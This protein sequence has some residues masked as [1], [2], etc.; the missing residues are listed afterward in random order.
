M[1]RHVRGD[2]DYPARDSFV[3]GSEV[4]VVCV[5]D[6]GSGHSH[7][8]G[9]GSVGRLCL[10]QRFRIFF[11]LGVGGVERVRLTEQ[12][13]HIVPKDVL[14]FDVG[15]L[16]TPTNNVGASSP[17]G[18]VEPD[19]VGNVQEPMR[20][21]RQRG[22]ATGKGQSHHQRRI[23]DQVSHSLEYVL[24]EDLR[25][26]WRKTLHDAD[27]RRQDLDGGSSHQGVLVLEQ[28]HR[29]R[30]NALK[31]GLIVRISSE[32]FHE[33]E[34]HQL[35]CRTLDVPDGRQHQLQINEQRA[36]GELGSVDLGLIGMLGFRTGVVFPVHCRAPGE[37]GGFV[38]S[39]G[40]YF[41]LI[42]G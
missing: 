10:S 21:L 16:R 32:T 4:A 27:G 1:I 19:G 6:Q 7:N 11:V 40:K 35:A 37:F 23:C 15:L 38:G 30:H 8:V 5:A 41:V 31:P 39:H 12:L 33:L 13:G 14:G 22:H 36:L 18:L 20:R 17:Y 24:G 26:G 3:Q 25:V 42:D 9:I 34:C 28:R 2:V 29:Y